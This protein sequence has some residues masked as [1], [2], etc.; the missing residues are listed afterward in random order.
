MS[1]RIFMEGK[2]YNVLRRLLA[3]GAALA[4]LIAIVCSFYQGYQWLERSGMV[5]SLLFLT[6]NLLVAQW[7]EEP[8]ERSEDD[9]QGGGPQ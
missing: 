9:E 3:A 5:A 2:T 7:R 1:P 6:A 8:P 4:M